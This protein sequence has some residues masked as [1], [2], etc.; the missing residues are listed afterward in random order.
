MMMIKEV[1]HVLHADWN[2]KNVIFT[3]VSTDSRTLKQGDLFIAL[4]GENFFGSKFVGNAAEK[5]AV[6]AMIEQTVEHHDIPVDIPLIRV[7]DTRLGLGQLAAHWRNR[8][9]LP[10]IGVTGSNG[11]TTVK[12]M[13]ASILR[14]A[15]AAG[16]AENNGSLDPVLA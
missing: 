10:L 3:G 11:K 9:M 4:T 8:F 16:A 6:A 7:K 12:E 13:I 2:G 1:A 15:T 14:Q 5:G